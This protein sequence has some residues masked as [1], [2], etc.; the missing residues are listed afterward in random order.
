[1]S[2]KQY[3]R[4]PAYARV[5]KSEAPDWEPRPRRPVTTLVGK[6]GVR[7]LVARRA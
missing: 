1:M 7:I 3:S 2:D 4:K 6:L 5:D